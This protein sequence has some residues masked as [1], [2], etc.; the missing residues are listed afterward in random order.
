MPTKN[1]TGNRYGRLIAL[2]QVGKTKTGNALWRCK[3]DC[4]K[5]V[6]VLSILLRK[7]ETKSCGCLRSEYWRMRKTTHGESDTRLAHIWYEMRARCKN[8]N[9]KCY[10]NYGGRGI[11]VCEEWERSFEAFRDWALS[12]G[13]SND[14][15]IDRIDNNGNYEPD[16]CRF[17]DRK[18]QANNRRPSTEWDFKKR[19][20]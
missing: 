2:E 18:T 12:H 15:T 7:G 10:K 19:N 11:S 17:A 1:I 13:Y 16:N 6:I 4:G 20:N 14:L 8:P 5:E 3:C 9:L